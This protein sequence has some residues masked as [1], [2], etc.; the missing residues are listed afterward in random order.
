LC[1]T[2]RDEWI[3]EEAQAHRD[4]RIGK[5]MRALDKILDEPITGNWNDHL[6]NLA[7]AAV[8]AADA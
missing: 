5:V 6:H 7:V 1:A 8:D 2:H 4:R 3:A